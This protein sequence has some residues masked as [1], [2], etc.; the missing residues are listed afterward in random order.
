MEHLMKRIA[1]A[2]AKY[3]DLHENRVIEIRS[4][5]ITKAVDDAQVQGFQTRSGKASARE[6]TSFYFATQLNGFYWGPV[7]F[8]PFGKNLKNKNFEWDEFS[9]DEIFVVRFLKLK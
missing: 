4:A 8:F 6:K 3:T 2:L 7:V 9:F 5:D 1:V